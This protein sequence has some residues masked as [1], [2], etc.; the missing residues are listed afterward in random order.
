MSTSLGKFSSTNFPQA[1]NLCYR[2]VMIYCSQEKQIFMR[3]LDHILPTCL[4]KL[5]IYLILFPHDALIKCGT[6]I[7]YKNYLGHMSEW[8]FWSKL[9]SSHRQFRGGCRIK[10]KGSKRRLDSKMHQCFGRI[11]QESWCWLERYTENRSMYEG[12]E[13][14]KCKTVYRRKWFAV[15]IWQSVTI[16]LGASLWSF[17]MVHTKWWQ[18]LDITDNIQFCHYLLEGFI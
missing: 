13:K 17:F 11:C 2:K 5:K 15:K 18:C 1:R 7:I 4:T 9:S 6:D 14:K 8:Q 16:H 3:V 10:F 12:F